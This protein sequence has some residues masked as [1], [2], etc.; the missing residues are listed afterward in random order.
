MDMAMLCS[1]VAEKTPNSR[2][3]NAEQAFTVG[4]FHDCGVA[5]LM[6]HFPSYCRAFGEPTAPLPNVLAQDDVFESSHCL[7][8]QM[9]AHEWNL[10]EFV[11][12]TVGHHHDPLA[13]VPA[14]G[15]PAC[16]ALQMSTHLVNTHGN[17]DDSAWIAQRP[18]VMVELGLS[19]ET[20]ADFENEVWTSYQML[21]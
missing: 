3:L 12:E 2:S 5:V 1:I 17:R 19:E 10:P 11:Y 18:V 7:V 4:L 21:H 8:G 16:A 9:V 15:A 13:E 14:V 6:Q 20:L